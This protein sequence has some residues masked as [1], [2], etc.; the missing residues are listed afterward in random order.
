VDKDI[1][2]ET[3]DIPPSTVDVDAEVKKLKTSILN[4]SLDEKSTIANKIFAINRDCQYQLDVLDICTQQQ[5]EVLT[6]DKLKE[7]DNSNPPQK[8]LLPEERVALP[9]VPSGANP[10]RALRGVWPQGKPSQMIHL[11]KEHNHRMT[12][13]IAY[14]VIPFLV[15]TNVENRCELKIVVE[16]YAKTFEDDWPDTAKEKSKQYRKYSH[17]PSE[18]VIKESREAIELLKSYTKL[19]Q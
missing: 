5:H 8:P 4:A 14:L 7:T 1:D 12:E 18:E 16:K 3:A 13:N 6:S 17:P 15:Q 9:Q 2:E 19:D 10:S 11:V